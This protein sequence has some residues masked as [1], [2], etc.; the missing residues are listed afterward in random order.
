MNKNEDGLGPSPSSSSTGNEGRK[1][2]TK[3]K[4]CC[5]EKRRYLFLKMI[6][7]LP[8]IVQ[9]VTRT[10]ALQHLS[11]TSLH[12]LPMITTNS[13]LNHSLPPTALKI[14][15]TV[16]S[17]TLKNGL[18]PLSIS[19]TSTPTLPPTQPSRE[20][21]TSIAERWYDTVSASSFLHSTYVTGKSA[22]PSC[23][24]GVKKASRTCGRSKEAACSASVGGT[25]L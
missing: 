7:T 16:S 18:C 9:P 1:F 25:S 24:V 23:C 20:R 8:A 2:A 14:T 21:H 5:Q 3:H 15:S 10:P 12:F 19:T 6:P 11:V 4:R 22:Q 17:G 13:H